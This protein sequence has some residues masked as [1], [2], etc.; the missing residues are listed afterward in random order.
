MVMEQGYN[1][2]NTTEIVIDRDTKSYHH[3]HLH[4]SPFNESQRNIYYRW[5]KPDIYHQCI[6]HRKEDPKILC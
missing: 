6:H 2:S 5:P 4:T 3:R 1:L